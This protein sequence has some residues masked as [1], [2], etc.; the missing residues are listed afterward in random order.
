MLLM[1]INE[2]RQKCYTA[3]S[4]PS[5]RTLKRWIETGEL[6]GKKHGGK[7]FIDVHLVEKL[8]GNPMVDK[9][10]IDM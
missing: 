7:Y 2:Y 3:D 6:P 4:R 1:E 9:F 5:L 10:L 8:T